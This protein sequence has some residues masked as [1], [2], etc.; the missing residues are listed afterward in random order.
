MLSGLAST[1]IPPCASAPHRCREISNPSLSPNLCFLLTGD[2]ARACLQCLL[3]GKV[4]MSR[5]LLHKMGRELIVLFQFGL[6]MGLGWDP[7]H[8]LV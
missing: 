1:P 3:L 8:L 5:T 6:E 2:E 4:S 7:A